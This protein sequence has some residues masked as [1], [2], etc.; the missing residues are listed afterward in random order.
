MKRVIRI[1]KSVYTLPVLMFVSLL[2]TMIFFASRFTWQVTAFG[3][4]IEDFCAILFCVMCAVTL[5][6]GVLLFIRVYKLHKDGKELFHTKIYSFLVLLTAATTLVSFLLAIYSIYKMAFYQSHFVMWLYF[7]EAFLYFWIALLPVVLVFLPAISRKAQIRFICIILVFTLVL[8]I[9]G[10][11][12]VVT[13][14]IVSAPMVIDNGT[15]YS[16]VFATNAEGTGYV[17]YSFNE[18]DYKVYD[19]IGGKLK[20]DSKIHSISVPYEHIRNNKYRVG[21]ENII[22]EYSYGAV[23]GKSIVSP[24]YSFSYK[25][26]E[27]TEL[28]IVSDWHTKT[29]RVFEAIK[30]AGHYDA[31]VLMGDSSPGVDFEEE[32]IRYTVKFAGELTGGVKPVIYLRGNHEMRGSYAIE[33]QEALGLENFYYTASFSNVDLIVLD[34]GEDKASFYKENGGLTEGYEATER[35]SEWLKTTKTQNDKAI[36]FSHWWRFSE[37]DEAVSEDIYCELEN[38]N[39]SLLISGHT[40]ECRLIG[41]GGEEEKQF[42]KTHPGITGYMCGGINDGKYIVSKLSISDEGFTIKAYDNLGNKVFGQII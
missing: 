14:K 30:E 3:T 27:R 17:E 42:V 13:Y 39:V 1:T 23:K 6:S 16:I 34:S 31:V 15:S 21:S 4:G 7:K 41:E 40:H 2:S 36:A 20:S 8:G 32:V 25:E 11:M 29:D 19:C 18:K 24:E 22:E 9:V 38:K 5:F 10:V 12:P 33:M 35:M 37:T 26:K 28:L